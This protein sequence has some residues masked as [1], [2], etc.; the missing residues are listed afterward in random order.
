MLCL[1]VCEYSLFIS[2][3]L[4]PLR[5]AF[6]EK[7]TMC[8]DIDESLES[9]GSLT[10]EET[11]TFTAVNSLLD[12]TVEASGKPGISSEEVKMSADSNMIR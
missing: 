6:E 1:T 4:S 11:S 8:C 9:Y 3:T 10:F 7:L 5:D 2:E 12:S